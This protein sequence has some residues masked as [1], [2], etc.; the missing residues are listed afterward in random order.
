MSD[1]VG[2]DGAFFPIRLPEEAH[3]GKIK[4]RAGSQ[5]QA[6]VLVIVESRPVDTVL[7]QYLSE[8]TGQSIGK[9]VRFAKKAE[10]QSVGKVVHYIKMFVIDNLSA[11]TLDKI[12]RKLCVVI[13]VLTNLK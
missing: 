1:E 6:R 3:G 13:K 8:A 12:V 10:R 2:L 11:G 5:Q 7:R 9:A 4:R